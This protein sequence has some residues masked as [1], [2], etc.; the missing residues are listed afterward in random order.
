[1]LG[2]GVEERGRWR[3]RSR[4]RCHRLVCPL[5]LLLLVLLPPPLWRLLRRAKHAQRVPTTRCPPPSP[6]SPRPPPQVRCIQLA[7]DNPAPAGEMRVYN[8]FTEQFSVNDLAAIVTREGAK[9]GLDVQVGEGDMWK[10]MCW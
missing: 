1:M 6:L 8:Q 5:P 4:R 2:G 3:D 9:L 10:G 7:V